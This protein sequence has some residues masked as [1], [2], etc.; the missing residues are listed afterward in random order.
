VYIAFDLTRGDGDKSLAAWINHLLQQEL[1]IWSHKHDVAYQ[2]KTVKY[3]T[4]VILQPDELYSFFAV[5]WNPIDP[6]FRNYQ[7]VEPMSL[8]NH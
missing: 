1:Q 8:D 3:I 6:D 2:I 5:T 4:R 7:V